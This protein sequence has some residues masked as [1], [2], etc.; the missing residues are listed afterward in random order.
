MAFDD[1]R[2]TVSAEAMDKEE[3]DR[4]DKEKL[5][6]RGSHMEDDECPNPLR[7]TNLIRFPSELHGI[8][9]QSG[10]VDSQGHE[11]WTSRDLATII[12]WD[13]MGRKKYQHIR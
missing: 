9:Q 11:K 6:Q 13:S 7:N 12:E 10:G 8:T 1:L 3:N 5:N 2:S 4:N